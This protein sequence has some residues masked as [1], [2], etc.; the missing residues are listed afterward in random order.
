MSLHLI[1]LLLTGFRVI[2]HSSLRQSFL[3]DLHEEQIGITKCQFTASTLNYWP[4]RNNNIEDNIKWF[5]TCVRL[6][7][8]LPAE[9][10][11]R[12]LADFID[13]DGKTFLL[14]IYFFCKYDFLVH[15]SFTNANA[16][17]NCLT[18]LFAFKET[19]KDVFTDNRQLLSSQEWYTFTDKYGFKHKISM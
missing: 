14:N 18:E 9:D 5:P 8:T 12:N 17:I 3:H 2:I 1:G 19:L 6:S 15:M 7:P 10:P 11:G 4:S 13:R 16:V